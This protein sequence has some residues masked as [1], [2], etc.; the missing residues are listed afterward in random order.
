MPR[1]VHFILSLRHQF[2]NQP[3]LITKWDITKAYRRVT[4]N[5]VSVERTLYMVDEKL[6][7]QFR[8]SFGGATNPPT[9][10]I[11][12][13]IIADLAN[14]LLECQDWHPSIVQAPGIQIPPTKPLESPDV[15]FAPA[16]A[17]AAETIPSECG[18]YDMYI[19]DGV[20]VFVDTPRNRLRVPA[21]LPLAIHLISRPLAV[22]EPIPREFWIQMEK[23]LEEASPAELQVILGWLFDTRRLLILLPPDKHLAWRSDI[24]QGLKDGFFSHADLLSLVG[25]L[26]HVCLV[27]P[28]AKYFMNRLEHKKTVSKTDKAKVISHPR[29]RH[30]RGPTPPSRVH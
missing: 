12:A 19:D 26:N 4:M 9:W 20:G 16:L 13:E 6:Y 30:K 28:I 17:L 21:A 29:R 15:P 10:C 14:E 3:I 1:L 25:R 18:R 22:N 23:A 7:I 11:P 27:V 8:L 5:G 2:P 24:E